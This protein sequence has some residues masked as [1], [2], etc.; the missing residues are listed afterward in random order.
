MSSFLTLFVLK[1]FSFVVSAPWPMFL[2]P[3]RILLHKSHT[4]LLLVISFLPRLT[5]MS[6]LGMDW[7]AV[8]PTTLLVRGWF[9]QIFRYF[10][11]LRCFCMLWDFRSISMV[12]SCRFFLFYSAQLTALASFWLAVIW[13]TSSWIRSTL[14]MKRFVTF[15]CPDCCWGTIISSLECWLLFFQW[16]SFSYRIVFLT[17]IL[18]K[19]R[20]RSVG[21]TCCPLCPRRSS[22]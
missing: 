16:T 8:S 10:G 14:A 3:T 9:I 18:L 1:M 5:P 20:T 15:N 17:R 13:K 11:F 21:C 4:P 19:K 12:C 7:R 6:F 22:A 2:R